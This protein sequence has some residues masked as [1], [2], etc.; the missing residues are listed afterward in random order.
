MT[1][2]FCNFSNSTKVVSVVIP[3]HIILNVYEYFLFEKQKNHNIKGFPD[4]LARFKYIEKHFNEIFKKKTAYVAFHMFAMRKIIQKFNEIGAFLPFYFNPSFYFDDEAFSIVFEQKVLGVSIKKEKIDDKIKKI[5][6]PVRKKYRDLDKQAAAFVKNENLAKEQYDKKIAFLDWVLIR[7]SFFESD[8]KINDGIFSLLWVRISEY[9]IDLEFSN[10]FIGK[11][12]GDKLKIKSIFLQK[13]FYLSSDERY[14]F[15]IEIKKV[16][17]NSYFDVE[18]LYRFFKCESKKD[19]YA[20]I[21]NTISFCN[22]VSIYRH[23]NQIIMNKMLEFFK[24]SIP[25]EYILE[26]EEKIREN[27]KYEPDYILFQSKKDF[28]DNVRIFVSKNISENVLIDHI[29]KIKKVKVLDEDVCLYFN[30]LQR[31]RIKD[32]IYFD[33]F[34]VFSRFEEVAIPHEIV[35]KLVLREKTIQTC[36]KFLKKMFIKNNNL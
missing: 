15:Y 11:K 31:K 3:K 35:L 27:I 13:H 2:D 10:F 7:V 21:I 36:S 22:D 25:N 32:F 33:N 6:F 23:T 24:V 26:V 14:D 5:K 29:S 18:N 28:N 34:F 19:L 12:E 17:S 8:K 4:G 16:V 9:K 20:N 30:I 1:E